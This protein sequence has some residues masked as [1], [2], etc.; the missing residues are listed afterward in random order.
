MKVTTVRLKID[1][2]DGFSFVIITLLNCKY[3]LS[4]MASIPLYYT[5][6]HTYF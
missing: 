1:I 5:L 3:Q 4:Q 2:F 6:I